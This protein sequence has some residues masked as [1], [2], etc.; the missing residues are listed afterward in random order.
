M[1][2]KKK[3]SLILL[4]ATALTVLFVVVFSIILERATIWSPFEDIELSEA[5]QYYPPSYQYTFTKEELALI[6]DE[7]RNVVAYGE[8]NPKLVVV[9][10]HSQSVPKKGC[11]RLTDAKGEM[12]TVDIVINDMGC[13]VIIN[14]VSYEGKRKTLEPLNNLLLAK[15]NQYFNSA[16][17][18]NTQDS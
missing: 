1:K 13:W 3:L 10:G 14:G 15:S 6:Q 18:E 17:Q 4:T 5:V 11:Y 7:L 9:D 12:T 8:E 16:T 2:V